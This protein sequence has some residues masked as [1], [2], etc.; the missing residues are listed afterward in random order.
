MMHVKVT[1]WFLKSHM[2][3]LIL[4]SIHNHTYILS[5]VHSEE[6]PDTPNTESA[7]QWLYS[8]E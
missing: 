1:V 4:E 8:V 6:P 2:L 5:N 7:G 3:V